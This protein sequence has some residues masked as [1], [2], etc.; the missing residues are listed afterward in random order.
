[1][2]IVSTFLLSM[3]F[4]LIMAQ[5][6]DFTQ[7]YTLLKSENKVNIYQKSINCNLENG[8]INND[9]IFL[10]V[11]NT[12]SHS[13]TVTWHYDLYFD[14]NCISCGDNVEYDFKITLKPG[15]SVEPKC[16]IN[17]P[18]TLKIFVK[19]N[20]FDNLYTF[21]KFELTNLKIEKSK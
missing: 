20:N 18:T 2:K 14:N 10:K 13:V 19:S 11:E 8:K 12:N 15:E 9:L 5:K 6:T 17:D 7:D 16:I 4:A 1:M 21:T 3:S